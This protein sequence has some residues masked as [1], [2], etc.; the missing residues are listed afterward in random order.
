MKQ[1]SFDDCQHI[2]AAL[3]AGCVIIIS[4]N[5]KHIVNVKTVRGVKF[6]GF[7]II[8][9]GSFVFCMGVKLLKQSRVR[10]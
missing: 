3:L 1:K 4:W 10:I 7:F 5:F 8:L 6:W 9:L 2:A